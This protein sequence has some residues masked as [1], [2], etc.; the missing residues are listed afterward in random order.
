M[1][2]NNFLIQQVYSSGAGY[3]FVGELILRPWTI[4]ELV[5]QRPD[6]AEWIAD[7]L[8]DPY[9]WKSYREAMEPFRQSWK[10][11]TSKDAQRYASDIWYLQHKY[12]SVKNY[13]TRAYQ[14]QVADAQDK[15][16]NGT[17][18]L[19]FEPLRVNFRNAMSALNAWYELASS[20]FAYKYSKDTFPAKEAYE[21]AFVEA[22]EAGLIASF[23]NE[24]L[25]EDSE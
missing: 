13:L 3:E 2:I 19:N 5:A 11:E 22:L 4:K 25:G 10:S 6:W 18:P 8:L 20:P 14:M 23:G 17:G 1:L 24:V 7:N 21:T 16:L 15:A 9:A 12:F